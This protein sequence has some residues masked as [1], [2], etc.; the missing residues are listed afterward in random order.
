MSIVLLEGATLTRK[1]AFRIVD[2]WGLFCV[3]I[4]KGE[5]IQPGLYNVSVCLHSIHVHIRLTR[6]LLLKQKYFRLFSFPAPTLFESKEYFR[7]TGVSS[8]NISFG[9]LNQIAGLGVA[10]FE[11]R[12]GLS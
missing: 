3:A 12:N 7:N 10:F 5:N 1:L 9:T 6:R 8:L 4:L 2:C 11:Y